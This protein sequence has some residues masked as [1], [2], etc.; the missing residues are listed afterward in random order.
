MGKIEYIKNHY[1]ILT[2]KE[3][4]DHLGIT[5]G[6]LRSLVYKHIPFENRYRRGKSPHSR[7]KRI[8]NLKDDSFSEYNNQ[9]C[10]WAGM[11]AA[12]GH[13]NKKYDSFMLGLKE[14]DKEHIEKFKKWLEF[15]GDLRFG[16]TKYEYKGQLCEKNSYSI[17]PT[18]TKI[19][20][21]LEKNF[22]ITR[23]KTLTLRPPENLEN[24]E[25][26]DCFIK[27]YID[28]D[29][30]IRTD[31]DNTS[32]LSIIG[33]YDIICWINERLE[34]IAGRRLP[35]PRKMKNIW[36]IEFRN[37]ISRKILKHFF[38]LKCPSLDRKWNDEIK[39]IVFNYKKRRDTPHYENILKL[40]KSGNNKTMISKILGISPSAVSWIT[41]QEHYKELESKF[42]IGES[43]DR[44]KGETNMEEEN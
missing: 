26:I 13:I 27:G 17:H 14:L 29:G 12:D 11:M 15:D 36:V 8:Y 4:S 30:S 28:G 44:D 42:L 18:S 1:G 41:K 38:Q 43:A 39:N 24:K 22:N 16:V 21:D 7:H 31:N 19:V 25:H 20:E 33:T 5:I 2:N 32:R 35:K 3:I 34:E 23:Q 9:S 10:Y 6:A 37:R 40:M